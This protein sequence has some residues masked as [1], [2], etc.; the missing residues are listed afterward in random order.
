MRTY[1]SA[2][3]VPLPFT[4]SALGL[5]LSYFFPSHVNPSLAAFLGFAA[6]VMLLYAAGGKSSRPESWTATD[7]ADLSR[8][9]PLATGAA[10]E[11]VLKH[12]LDEHLRH[13]L[14][15]LEYEI[16]ELQKNQTRLMKH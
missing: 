11:S 7:V 12:E 13:Q 1:S 15:K 6:G 5:L 2:T 10:G 14:L 8:D 16:R 4:T 3:A 9:R